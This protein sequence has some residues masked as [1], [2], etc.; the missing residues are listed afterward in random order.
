MHLP[1]NRDW[2]DFEK[3]F[4]QSHLFDWD[5]CR[6]TEERTRPCWQIN[7]SRPK[8]FKR[9]PISLPF[10]NQIL[11]Y[12]VNLIVEPRLGKEEEFIQ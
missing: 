6:I 1:H 11:G 2:V 4:E 7:L 8:H 9:Y 10:P 3:I 5:H 12:T